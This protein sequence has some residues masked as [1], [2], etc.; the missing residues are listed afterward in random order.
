MAVDTDY[1]ALAAELVTLGRALPR[2]EP[3]ARLVRAV[4]VRLA[5]AAPPATSTPLDLLRARVADTFVRRRRQAVVVITAVLLALLAAPPVRAA[6][7]DW[8]GFGGVIVRHDPTP[9]GSPASRPSPPPSVAATTTLDEAMT[10]VTFQPV[11]PE[12]LGPPQGVEVS[13]DRRVLSM[14]W[15]GGDDG[16]VRVDQFDAR[17]DY[18]FAKT[19]RD[20][21]F[22]EVAGASALWFEEPHE[23]VVLNA[24]GTRRT[25]T[26]R[27]AGHTLIWEHGTTTV[28]LEADVGLA[29]AIEIAESVGPVP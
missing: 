27:L 20:V 5:D 21:R 7:A 23:V 19:A 18:T 22:T 6:V 17:L 13:A 10:L 28:R 3:T 24:D 12:V 9:S 2:P 26:A 1:D 8:F 25:E 4:T 29:R 11:V 14:S 16:A 15:S